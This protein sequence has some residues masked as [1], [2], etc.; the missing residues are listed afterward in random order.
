MKRPTPKK[1]KPIAADADA[2]ARPKGAEVAQRSG[3]DPAVRVFPIW[4]QGPD[5]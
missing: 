1:P 2:K 4:P 5:L 3:D